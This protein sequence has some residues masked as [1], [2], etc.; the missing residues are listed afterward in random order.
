MKV[1]LLLACA[2]VFFGVASANAWAADGTARSSSEETCRACHTLDTKK[3]GPPFRAIAERY[4]ND[5][6]A[7]AKLKKSMME[8]STG[9]WGTAQMPP[10]AISAADADRF[11]HWILSLNQHPAKPAAPTADASSHK[12]Q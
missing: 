7:V 3:I 4:G 1:T 8:G 2:T 6:D 11:A 12:M 9:K 10:N 5:A